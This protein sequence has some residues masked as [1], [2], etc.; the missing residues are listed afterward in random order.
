MIKLYWDIPLYGF[1]YCFLIHFETVALG[2]YK[3]V[4]YIFIRYKPDGLM[5]YHLMYLS[6]FLIIMF[7]IKVYFN[8]GRL[9]SFFS[10][11]VHIL[12]LFPVFNLNFIVSLNSLDIFVSLVSFLKVSYIFLLISLVVSNI[13]ID[14]YIFKCIMFLFWFLFIHPLSFLIPHIHNLLCRYTFIWFYFLPS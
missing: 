3:Y 6:L 8:T 11:I 14:I 9:N 5:F 10:V 7:Y 1:I 13:I 12:P 4:F 2:I